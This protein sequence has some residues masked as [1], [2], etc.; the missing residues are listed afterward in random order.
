MYRYDEYI[1]CETGKHYVIYR[2]WRWETFWTV[3]LL[4]GQVSWMCGMYPVHM[5]LRMGMWGVCLV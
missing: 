2:L 4:L 3:K 1:L 5:E